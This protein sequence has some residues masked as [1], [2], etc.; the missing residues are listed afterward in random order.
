MAFEDDHPI[1]N[2]NNNSKTT[3]AIINQPISF[4]SSPVHQ[5]TSALRKV[6]IAQENTEQLNESASVDSFAGFQSYKNNQNSIFSS[7]KKPSVDTLDEEEHPAADLASNRLSSTSSSKRDERH[8]IEDTDNLNDSKTSSSYLSSFLKITGSN[9][10]SM[11]ARQ[12]AAFAV[13]NHL[14]SALQAELN[15]DGSSAVTDQDDDDEEAFI[16]ATLDE[17]SAHSRQVTTDPLQEQKSSSWFNEL[18]S[19]FKI[20]RDSFLGAVTNEKSEGQTTD[21]DFWGK[22]INDYE[23]MN[24]S[25]PRQFQK[26]LRKG[27]PE[28]IRGMMWQLMS[29]SKN[30]MLEE[31]S[32]F[33]SKAIIFR[34]FWL[35]FNEVV[36]TKKSLLEI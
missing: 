16:L 17:R 31:V 28:P 12:A 5:K 8:L 4:S 26:N 22:V 19:G 30:E 7:G 21:W 6:E 27:L 23:G 1:D 10:V 35:Y 20:A 14:E 15:Q 33:E 18:Q 11:L 25:H 36:E 13:P 32:L 24:R 2:E 9:P 29:N 3:P 34:N